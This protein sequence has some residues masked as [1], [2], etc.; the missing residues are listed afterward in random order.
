MLPWVRNWPS[1]ITIIVSQ[2]FEIKSRSCSIIIKVYFFSLF[3][4]FI[5]LVIFLRSV[6]LTPAPTSSRRMISGSTIITLPNSKSFF[7]PPDKF[8]AYSF[9]KWLKPRIS[10]ISFAFFTLISSIFFIFFSKNH[11]PKNVSPILFGGTTKR[12]SKTVKEK[13]SCGIW[14]VLKTPISNNSCGW[15]PINS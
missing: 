11:W 14:K 9:S 2:S 6:L 12:L 7:W 3:N 1:A 8:P 10:S 13:N 5:I 15:R 4:F